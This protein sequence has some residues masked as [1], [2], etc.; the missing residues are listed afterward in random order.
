MFSDYIPDGP[1][2]LTN[3]TEKLTGR[4]RLSGTSTT[5]ANTLRRS[6]LVN[7]RSVGFRADLTNQAD[8]GVVITKNTSAV[9]NEMLAHRLTLLPVGMSPNDFDEKYKCVLEVSNATKE[10]MHVSAQEYR[11]GKQTIPGFRVLVKQETG[12]YVEDPALA[13]I[14]FPVDPI[15][16]R[17]SLIV[18]LRPQWNEQPPEE[19]QLEATPVV[20]TGAEHMGFSP[21]AC[22]AFM[23]TLDKDPVRQDAAYKEWML[24]FK[25][26]TGEGVDETTLKGYRQEWENMAIQRCF[27]TDANGEP[28]S[29]DFTVE[30][31]GIRPVKEIVAEGIQAVIDL[32]TPYTTDPQITMSQTDGRMN[33]VDVIFEGQEHTLGNLLQTII[34]D[35]LDVQVLYVGYKVPHPLH[36]RM[37]LR[38][39]FA[40]DITGEVAETLAKEVV[41][42]AAATAVATFRALA[43]AWAE[44]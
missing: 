20:R 22:C 34:S 18:S 6:I 2:L 33:G 21:V 7:T 36:H 23:Y 30:S 39:G 31:V 35:Q 11:D 13:Q 38:L 3:A 14:F 1:P 42:K 32:V 28:S 29:F 16:K 25:N 15:T 43:A 10:V 17:S 5:I 4:F 19:I 41:M 40:A 44:V 26:T 12:E 24:A 9:F 37:L 8:T 27:I